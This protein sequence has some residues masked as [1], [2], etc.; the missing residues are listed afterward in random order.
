[1]GKGTDKK[2]TKTWDAS[3]FTKEAVRAK[4]AV[5]TAITI[6]N[7]ARTLLLSGVSMDDVQR[8]L[9]LNP[10]DRVYIHLRELLHCNEI[11]KQKCNTVFPRDVILPEVH[12]DLMKHLKQLQTLSNIN[13]FPKPNA[14][15]ELAPKQIGNL[16]HVLKTPDTCVHVWSSINYHYYQYH[17]I[18][19]GVIAVAQSIDDLQKILTLKH[20]FYQIK[21]QCNNN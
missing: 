20:F 16:L 17:S 6:S 9:L 1:M 14:A 2:V 19:H 4:K 5:D 18:T 10:K 11:Q 21:N 7:K 3:R 8:R 13:D 15:I 12:A